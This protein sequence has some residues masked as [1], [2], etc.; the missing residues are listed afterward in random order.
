MPCIPYVAAAPAGDVSSVSQ[1]KQRKEG[2]SGNLPSKEHR[3]KCTNVVFG[4][5][6]LV[7]RPVNKMEMLRTPA[8]EAAVAKEWERLRLAGAW[9]ESR[10]TGPH[11][12]G[13]RTLP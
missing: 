4:P 2:E 12:Q 11:W 8:A 7:A 5:L 6:A 10:K 3:P 13:F 1:E 9:D